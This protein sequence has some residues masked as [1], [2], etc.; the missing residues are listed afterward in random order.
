MERGIRP[1]CCPVRSCRGE[2]SF[3]SQCKYFVNRVPEEVMEN[4]NEGD[5]DFIK[6]NLPIEHLLDQ[7]GQDIR[8]DAE[9]EGVVLFC[10]KVSRSSRGCPAI[11]SI[12]SSF[13][14]KH[15]KYE[16]FNDQVLEQIRRFFVFLY[17]IITLTSKPKIQDLPVMSPRVYLKYR[18]RAMTPI[19]VALHSLCLAKL[20]WITQRF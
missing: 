19:F 6:D 15:G 8:Q 14:L 5:E 17:P 20:I 11:K 10:A 12:T 9:Q 3:T 1:Y 13:V 4:L 2:Y 7:H 18:M 16:A